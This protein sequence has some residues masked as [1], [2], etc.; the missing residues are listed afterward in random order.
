VILKKIIP[1]KFRN[2]VRS[3]KV[4]FLDNLYLFYY[5]RKID[6][7]K[8]RVISSSKLNVVFVL[9]D[10]TMW[11]YE[12]LYKEMHKE[13]RFD[14]LILIAPRINQNEEGIKKD[15][16]K[17]INYFKLKEYNFLQGYNFK[18]KSWVNIKKKIHADIVFYTQPYN[19]VAVHKNYSLWSFKSSLFC[20]VPY[21]FPNYISKM[22]V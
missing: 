12:G 18:K 11:K 13:K 16:L 17:M 4:N 15:T 19:S 9:M 3:L 8:K 6:S 10:L 1:L 5:K 21:F 2:Q 22:G 20:Y 7:I 14:P